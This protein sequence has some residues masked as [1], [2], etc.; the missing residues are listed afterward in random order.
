MVGRVTAV[1]GPLERSWLVV[2]GDRGEVLIPLVDSICT[3]VDPAARTIVV[4]P[5]EGLID[6]NARDAQKAGS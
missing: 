4:D 1:E 2:T 5:P 6:L 3:S